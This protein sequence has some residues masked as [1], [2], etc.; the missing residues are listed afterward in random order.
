MPL[1]FI[2]ILVSFHF[3]QFWK[4]KIFFSCFPENSL[5]TDEKFMEFDQFDFWFEKENFYLGLYSF[6]DI[7]LTNFLKATYYN[8]YYKIWCVDLKVILA[9][10]QLLIIT[11]ILL[12][13]NY[14]YVKIKAG[15]MSVF[16]P[17]NFITLVGCEN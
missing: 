4:Q 7:K 3:F 10:Y 11:S 16:V 15:A 2:N 17:I 1:Y 12:Y 13:H 5:S 14:S 9:K 6:F 8:A